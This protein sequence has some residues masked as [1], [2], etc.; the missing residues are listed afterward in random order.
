MKSSIRSTENVLVLY[1]TAKNIR[2]FADHLNDESN[3]WGSID[4]ENLIQCFF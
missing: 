3:A 2:V 1:A 4:Y